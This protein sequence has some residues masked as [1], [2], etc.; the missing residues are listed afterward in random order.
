MRH[1]L[2]SL[3]LCSAVLATLGCSGD[4]SQ[5]ALSAS[6]QQP[7]LS[8]DSSS[9]GAD[10]NGGFSLVMQLGDY[11]SD[12]TEVSLGSFSIQ[13][14]EKDL[15]T[16]LSL[17]GG[18]FPVSLGVGKKVMLP[19]TF[20]ESTEPSVATDLCQAPVQIRGTLMDTLSNDHPTVAVSATFTPTCN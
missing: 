16:P 5:V 19:M 14:D 8:V 2:A 18:T 13:R 12:P 20:T 11:A 7:M 3:C 4:K 17:A 6:V 10:A 1:L 9:V 15:L